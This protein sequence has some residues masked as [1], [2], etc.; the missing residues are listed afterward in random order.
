MSRLTRRQRRALTDIADD[1][2][3]TRS[4]AR[5][6]TVLIWIGTIATIVGIV[7]AVVFGVDEW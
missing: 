1:E 6:G 3:T 5:I 7:V 4:A 2:A